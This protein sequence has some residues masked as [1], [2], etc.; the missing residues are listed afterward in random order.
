MFIEHLISKDPSIKR[1][2][3]KT[4]TWRLVGTIDTVILGW[5]VTGNP[6]TGLTIGGF[7]LLAKIIL[8]YFHE[9]IWFR[10]KLG[11]PNRE[12]KGYRDKK[13]LTKNIQGQKFKIARSHRNKLNRHQSFV[14]WFTG[15]SGAGKSTLANGIEQALFAKNIR[16][17]ALDGDNVRLGINSDL[18]F[19]TEGR[20][21]NIR[22]VAE[23]AKL[24]ADAGLIVIMSLISPFR[25]DRQKAKSII[26]EEYFIEVFVDCP[27][28]VCEERDAKGLYKKARQGTIKTLPASAA[29]MKHLNIP[30]SR[31]IPT[32]LVLTKA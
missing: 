21:E 9:R 3:A 28:E 26:G 16:C 27:L 11:L 31:F 19:T 24:M 12:R 22:R 7:E 14:I 13:N 2:V 17:Y 10:A 1:H 6:T 23:I 4:L 20:N 25:E 30:I 8:N 15:L 5:I 18:D 32:G 29:P